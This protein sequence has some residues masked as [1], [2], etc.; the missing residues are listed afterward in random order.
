M[1]SS[2][3]LFWRAIGDVAAAAANLGTALRFETISHDEPSDA[4]DFERFRAWL[5]ETYPRSEYASAARHSRARRATC[6]AFDRWS[7]TIVALTR[8]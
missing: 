7:S 4:P 2:K 3:E 8:F 5:V 6:A 1:R